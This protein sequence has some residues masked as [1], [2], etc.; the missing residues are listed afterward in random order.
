MLATKVP[1]TDRRARA[2]QS[3]RPGTSTVVTSVLTRQELALDQPI[4]RIRLRRTV[5]SAGYG[6]GYREVVS[7]YLDGTE[8]FEQYQD[9]KPV[10]TEWRMATVRPARSAEVID[11][12]TLRAAVA[13]LATQAQMYSPDHR[14]SD[15]Q[16]TSMLHSYRQI[17]EWRRQARESLSNAEGA[18]DVAATFMKRLTEF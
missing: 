4:E 16:L 1:A 18:I 15:A 14:P 2:G 6:E 12:G 11:I 5:D 17:L 10:R 13:A 8:C 3:L 9:G 7:T